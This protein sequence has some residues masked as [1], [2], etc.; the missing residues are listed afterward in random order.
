L[1]WKCH[2][3]SALLTDSEWI[4]IAAILYLGLAD[5]LAALVGAKWGKHRYKILSNTK[6]LEGSLAFMLISIW[7]TAWVV[8][9]APAGLENVW[10]IILWLP[11][12]ATITEGLSPF[13]SDNFF[14]PVL[15]TV[16]LSSLSTLG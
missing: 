7:I 12:L 4:F 5:S 11:I 15:V 16:V 6:S 14:V 3:K 10:P 1:A 2:A 13:G 8:L 9:V